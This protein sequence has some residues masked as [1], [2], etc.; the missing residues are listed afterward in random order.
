[1]VGGKSL[2]TVI[3]NSEIKTEK[4]KMIHSGIPQY[5]ESTNL[6]FPLKMTEV[7]R[8]GER[9]IIWFIDSSL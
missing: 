4:K 7:I 9:M 8:L 2:P 6:I 5:S 1:M 3:C